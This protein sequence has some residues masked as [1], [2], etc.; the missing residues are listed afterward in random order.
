MYTFC[1]RIER[2]LLQSNLTV[3]KE[4]NKLILK[5]YFGYNE[6]FFSQIDDLIKVLYLGSYPGALSAKPK[7]SA[8]IPSAYIP[9]GYR[10]TLVPH[11]D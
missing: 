9:L 10:P 6:K 7:A 1:H 3:L 4:L 5:V 11:I 8:I 2:V